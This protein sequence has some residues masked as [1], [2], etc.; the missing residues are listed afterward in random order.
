MK[1]LLDECFP[2]PMRKMLANHECFT[3][4]RCGWNGV[5]NGELRKLAEGKFEFFMT[6]DRNVRYQH[7]LTGRQDSQ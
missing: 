3:P 1:I 6:A 7:N 4:F 2:W 5:T